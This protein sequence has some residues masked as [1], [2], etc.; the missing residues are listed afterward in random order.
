LAFCDVSLP[1]VGEGLP[2]V[3]WAVATAAHAKRDMPS[4]RWNALDK[5][6]LLMAVLPGIQ[7]GLRKTSVYFGAA[8]ALPAGAALRQ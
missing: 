6:S 4:V 5:V 8:F 3:G 2:N 7:W 1:A